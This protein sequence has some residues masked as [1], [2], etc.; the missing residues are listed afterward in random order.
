MT[1]TL[2][3]AT[4]PSRLAQWQTESIVKQLKIAWPTL[5]CKTLVIT[6]QGDK[7]LDR[8]LPEIGGKGLFTLELEQ[9]LRSKEVDAAVHS[10]KDL[11]VENSPGLIVGL[12]PEREDL[13]DVL[14]CSAGYTLETMPSGSVVGTS[15]FRR[16]AQL[17]IQRPDLQVRS[18]RGNV[19][20][21]I[22]KSKTVAYDAIVMAAAGVK[23]LGL[24]REITSYF[25][26][27]VILAAPGQGALGVQCRQ[28]DLATQRLLAVLEDK[29]ARLTTTAERSFLA[30]LGGGCSLPVA[31][32]AILQGDQIYLHGLVAAADGS[33]VIRV[34]AKGNDPQLLGEN[35]A[36]QALDQGAGELL[37]L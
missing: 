4:R 7:V 22:A 31:A 11:P 13:R 14:I 30:A 15:S 24:E 34:Q 16:Q 23:R 5:N 8:P 37:N 19:E 6:T 27:E 32:Q 10:L 2:I 9:A 26:A 18:I 21:R 17:L 36:K 25:P 12:I 3:F 33:R 29:S 20:T 28:D 1:E 35:L